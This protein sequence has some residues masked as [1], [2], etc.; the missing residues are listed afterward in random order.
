MQLCGFLAMGRSI[1]ARDGEVSSLPKIYEL[2]LIA[3]VSKNRQRKE[4]R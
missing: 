3:R 1:A 2:R 4:G